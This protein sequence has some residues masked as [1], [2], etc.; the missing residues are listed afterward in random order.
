MELKIDPFTQAHA[1]N[2][3]R[4]A[5]PRTVGQAVEGLQNLLI[6]GKRLI[7]TPCGVRIEAKKSCGERRG[8]R[9]KK[10]PHCGASVKRQTFALYNPWGAGWK[11]AAIEK[12]AE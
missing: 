11:S 1:A 4:V 7:E 10:T 2:F 5:G 12:T 6:G 3:F 8:C 9:Q